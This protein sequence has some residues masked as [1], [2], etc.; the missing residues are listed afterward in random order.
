MKTRRRV[1]LV[2]RR[3]GHNARE[4][5]RRWCGSGR[6]R[7]LHLEVLEQ[8]RLLSVDTWSAP[9]AMLDFPP[10]NEGVPAAEELDLGE[11]RGRKWHDLNGD[12]QADADEPGLADWHVYVDANENGQWDADEPDAWTDADGNY[13]IAGLAPG[14]Y[15]VDEVPQDGW[16]RTYPAG[17]LNYIEHIQ[18][19][20]G[21][22]MASSV[23]VSSDGRDVY[24]TGNW[25]DTLSVF[26]RDAITGELTQIQVL[27]HGQGGISSLDGPI[28]VAVSPDDAYVCVG[29]SHN[30][31]N[32]FRRDLTT[33]TLSFV[34]A[35]RV[36]G[37]DCVC[38]PAFSPDGDHV[39]VVT[40]DSALVVFGRAPDTGQLNYVQ[41][42][43]DGQDGVDGLDGASSVAISPDGNHVYATG[44]L[45]DALAVFQRDPATGQLSLLEVLKDGQG[46]VEGMDSAVDVT[47]S[48]DGNHVYATGRSDSAVVVFRRDP[49]TGSLTPLQVLRNHEDGIDGLSYISC[50]RVS[51]DGRHVYTAA[52][53][54]NAVATFDRD[55]VT[56]Q[57]TFAGAL[58]DGRDGVEGLVGAMAVAIS[59]DGNHL[60]CAAFLDSA[61]ATFVRDTTTGE[62][63]FVQ[64]ITDGQGGVDG[65]AGARSA[66]VSPDGNHVYV[67]GQRDNA[68]A[69]FRRDAT[70]GHVEFVQA[71]EDGQQ[72]VEGLGGASSVT[73]SPDGAYVYATGAD[74]DAL[75]VF[76][77]D[78]ASGELSFRQLLRDGQAGVDGLNDPQSVAVSP[79]NSH[80]YVAGS[81]ENAVALFRR[82]PATGELVFVQMIH[83]GVDGVEGLGHVVSIAVSPDG[84]HVYT[85]ADVDN[86][87][88]AFRRDPA[89]GRLSLEQVFYDDQDVSRLAGVRWVA[90]SPDG[91]SVY[92]AASDDH[93]LNVFR[94]SE[95]TGRLA[96]ARRFPSFGARVVVTGPNGRHVYVASDSISVYSCDPATGELQLI[97]TLRNGERGVEGLATVTGLGASPDGNHMYVT[98]SSRL[99]SLRRGGPHVLDLAAGET[100]RDVD[101]GSHASIDFGDAPDPTYPVLAIN[102]GAGHMLL[103]GGPRMGATVDPEPNGQPDSGATGDDHHGTADEDGVAWTTP[104]TASGPPAGVDVDLSASPTGGF[105]NAWIDFNAD[106]DWDDPDEQIF[107]DEM[108]AAGAVHSL[109]F[110]V[111]ATAALGPTFARFRLSTQSGLSPTGLAPDGEVEDYLAQIECYPGS[112]EGAVWNDF[113]GDG[114]W[115]AD[116]PPLAGREVYVDVDQNG[117]W[118][119]EEPKTWSDTE[120]R[121]SISGVCPGAPVVSTIP[122]DGWQQ[123]SPA[124]VPGTGTLVYSGYIGGIGGAYSV[125]TSPD[126]NFV[127][128]AGRH[129]GAVS[130]FRRDLSLLGLSLVQVVVDGQGGI[131]GL[132]DAFE[133]T[134]SPDGRHVY[135]AGKDENAVGVFARNQ[136]TGELSLVQVVRGDENDVDGLGRVYS[137]TVSPEGHHVYAASLNDDSVTVF[138][139]D[140]DT[141]ELDFVQVLRDNEEGIDGL[142]AADS[143]IV[144]RDGN[145]VY[146]AGRGEAAVA[147]FRRSATSDDLMFV[148]VVKGVAGLGSARDVIES[149]DGN[150]IYVAG[151]LGDAVVVFRRDPATGELSFVQAF[152]EDEAGYGVVDGPHG[153]AISPDGSR[154]YVAPYFAP[155]VVVCRR[156]PATGELSLLDRAGYGLD[157]PASVVVSPQGEC[158][159]FAY[160]GSDRL[161]PFRHDDG[162]PGAHQVE[163]DPG[164]TVQGVQFGQHYTGPPQVVDRHVFYNNSAFDGN[165]PAANGQDDTAIATDKQALLPGHAATVA[166]YT[167]YSRGINGVM[168]DLAGL[169]DGPGIAAADFEFRVG[170]D[171][172][173][174]GWAD[175]PQPT[176]IT[177][178]Q[179][180]GTDGS[181]RVTIVWEDGAIQKQWLEMMV[182]ANASTGLAEPDVF[183]FGNAVA[184]AGNSPTDARVNA[185]DMLLARNNPRTFLQPAA[186]D[187]PYDYNRDAR[188][189]ATDVLLARNNQTHFLSALKLMNLRPHHGIAAFERIAPPGSLMSLSRDNV[190][191]LRTAGEPDTARVSAEAGQTIS[192]VAVPDDPGATLW[193]ELRGLAGPFVAPGPGQPAVLPPVTIPDDSDYPLRTGGDMAT[194]YRLTVGKNLIQEVSDTDDGAPLAIDG[195]LVALGS[196]RYGVLGRFETIT[197]DLIINGGFETGDF[198]G[199]QAES[200]GLG[201]LTRWTVGPAG[202]GFFF[203]SQPLAGRY[204]AYNGF[205]GQSGLHYTLRQEITIPAHAREA[206]LTTN[207]RITYGEGGSAAEL[208][209]FN[210]EVWDAV[211]EVLLASYEQ[212][213][214]VS[215]PELDLGWTTQTFELAEH[216][217]K[218]VGIVF[219]EWVPESYTGPALLELDEV[220]LTVVPGALDPPEVDAYTLDL[221]GKAGHALDIVLASQGLADFSGELLELIGPDGVSVLA[222]A[223]VDPLGTPAASY[224]LGVLGFLVPADGVYTLRLTSAT[225]GEYGIVVTDRLAFESEPDGQPTD[226]LRSLGDVDA[227]LGYLDAE[228][229]DGDWYALALAADDSV[230]I[231]ARRASDDPAG[232]PLN[233]LDVQLH[234][235]T[236]TGGAVDCVVEPVPE[237]RGVIARFVAA[238]TGT[239]LVRISAAAGQGEYLLHFSLSLEA[240][241]ALC[242][243]ADRPDWFYEL[244]LAGSSKRPSGK[245]ADR[246][247]PWLISGWL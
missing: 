210:I 229:T 104:L 223:A 200:N 6:F 224:D 78:A 209:T 244:A 35:I 11:I 73:L 95:L 63:D 27:K 40:S 58:F 166:N 12:G 52:N 109:S 49:A 204:S 85:A 238:Q 189:N 43:Y 226:P 24:V 128:V 157:C 29:T 162:H 125:A 160:S 163:L 126:G 47:V 88:A 172:E 37:W 81:G 111:P 56:G 149:P 108:L 107:A 127:Y 30:Y 101:F 32:M 74:D 60:Y 31:V 142:A 219:A 216:A 102:R 23:A 144:S 100:E 117:R 87:L 233:D 57:L 183:Y 75:V 246:V 237:G 155:M 130:V 152:D 141:G 93:S 82:D 227:A 134:V 175:A 115:G 129:D 173:P 72:G 193:I 192:A 76:S 10:D 203:D 84:S 202:G 181:D 114:Q 89:T 213:V 217:G 122:P 38:S 176:G 146:V 154:L 243:A 147:V 66:T 20:D 91:R 44:E 222:T 231:V 194:D 239:Y 19:V 151:Y 4:S 70:T 97:D 62:L 214:W 41:A 187:F 211:E 61:V 133:V 167:S 196:G 13:A 39:Y 110:S 26:R 96:F 156:D 131:P 190:G 165:D 198:S 46:G 69:V 247:D 45:D 33:G 230:Q 67:A 221:T 138:R 199:W 220:R 48:P 34:Q 53:F 240:V 206:T 139:R 135:L 8:R 242:R 228:D 83:N 106:G 120:G 7:P 124:F 113:D 170:N 59:P 5:S 208:R 182:L 207:H 15:T 168:V 99:L 161:V 119:L 177:V 71:I 28:S 2:R 241:G 164:G 158:V 143:V 54:D 80:V 98:S 171:E 103:A 105:L 86:A 68:V 136:E 145:H 245:T 184:D 94:R 225:L 64:V 55:A 65:L 17:Q 16:Q 42:L 169:P 121:F 153:I 14:T 36:S 50:T 197:E 205:D 79:D 9:A 179:G 92:A 178:R 159:Y 212:P 188:V 191:T 18:E 77:R 25:D 236:P 232:T 22:R 174:A 118:T 201:E 123:S 234:V 112:I 21:L 186:V 180:A 132:T 215:G 148:Q 140:A 195:S 137:V 116:E 150:H 90:V 1:P 218:T 185:T 3:G 51:P 235:L